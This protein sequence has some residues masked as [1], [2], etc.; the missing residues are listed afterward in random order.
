MKDSSKNTDS[1]AHPPTKELNEY[2]ESIRAYLARSGG[3]KDRERS[4][5]FCWKELDTVR[6][7]HNQRSSSNH[8]HQPNATSSK[9]KSS[10]AAKKQSTQ[11]NFPVPISHY[12]D[13]MQSAP[14]GVFGF[15]VLEVHITGPSR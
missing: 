2:T 15:N 12:A 1:A 11:K 4:P 3:G 5:E 6:N 14:D 13:P 8:H 9:P 10:S 7:S